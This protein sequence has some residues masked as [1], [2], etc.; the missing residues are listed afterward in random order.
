MEN[1]ILSMTEIEGIPCPVGGQR[2]DGSE[3]TADCQLC[4]YYLQ[5]IAKA[6]SRHL[7]EYLKEPCTEHRLPVYTVVGLNL[8]AHRYEC[9]HCMAEIEKEIER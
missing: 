1:V 8:P 5:G 4:D 6:Q 3:C 9:S 2:R 7:L